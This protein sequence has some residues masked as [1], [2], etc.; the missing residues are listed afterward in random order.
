MR[1]EHEVSIAKLRAWH[2][3]WSWSAERYGMGWRYVGSHL[4]KHKVTV[5]AVSIMAGE[6]RFETQWRIDDGSKSE[7]LSSW[8]MR[9]MRRV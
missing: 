5:Y 7:S 6:D 9:N 1:L 8:Q 4:E 2:P 3:E